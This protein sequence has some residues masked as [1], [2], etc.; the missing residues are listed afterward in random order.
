MKTLI[1]RSLL[2]GACLAGAA[3]LG[4]CASLNVSPTPGYTESE[5]DAQITRNWTVQWQELA[6]DVDS[7]LLLRPDTM[8]SGWD[9]YHRQ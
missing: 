2:A 3:M 8:L 1:K 5:R 7:A 9:V 4:G 6:D